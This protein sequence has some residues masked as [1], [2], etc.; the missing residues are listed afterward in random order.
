MQ[1][2]F[3]Y[4]T[5]H[6]GEYDPPALF[7]GPASRGDGDGHASTSGCSAARAR[8]GDH[9]HLRL[10]RRAR[11]HGALRPPAGLQPDL[12][13]SSG[14]PSRGRAR[15]TAGCCR[16]AAARSG[17]PA[18]LTPGLRRG[19]RP[20][21]P[22]PRRRRRARRLARAQD[23]DLHRRW[24]RQGRLPARP[25]IARIIEEAQDAGW[26]LAVAS[27]SAEPSVRAILEQRGRRQ[28]GRP[29][30]TSCWPATSSRTRSRR[31]TSTCW[32]SIDSALQPAVDAGHRGL[33]QRPSRPR[34][35]RDCAAS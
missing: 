10:R 3:D 33:A 11:G 1:S 16:S 34:S 25:G 27:T 7:R 22:N 20:A 32:P 28:S 9:A 15:S 26:T 23:R 12:R 29:A 31:R 6:P 13:A 18:L 4:M 8:P 35:A 5:A 19:R 21:R 2:G 17:W 30:S 14:C 24:S